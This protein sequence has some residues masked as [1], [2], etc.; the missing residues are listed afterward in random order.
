MSQMG[1]YFSGTGTIPIQTITGNSGTEVTP[2]VTGNVDILGDTTGITTVG[3]MNTLTINLN[4]TITGNRIFSGGVF[5]VNSGNNL[6]AISND[7]FD[8][9]IQIGTPAISG[10]KTIIMG[11]VFGNSQI[12][13]FYGNNGFQVSSAFAT[14]ISAN[15]D[16]TLNFSAQPTFSAY[17]SSTQSNV[18]GDGT[19][20]PVVFDTILVNQGVSTY[21]DTGTGIFTAP[22]FGN[23]EFHAQVTVNGITTVTAT[24]CRL[25]TSNGIFIDGTATVGLNTIIFKISGLTSLQQGDTAFVDVQIVDAGGKIDDV[26]GAAQQYTFFTGKMIS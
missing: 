5:T 13:L 20:Y 9:Q 8:T 7:N 6:I 21:Y 17:L 24:A 26:F 15:L 22:A 3:G 4:E 2:D 1:Q 14:T 10:Q 19:V 23:Y 18:T 25:V 12:G 11:S 16:G